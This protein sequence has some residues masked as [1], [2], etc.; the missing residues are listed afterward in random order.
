VKL[1]PDGESLLIHPARSCFWCQFRH[2]GRDCPNV[3]G[4]A[5]AQVKLMIQG[6]ESEK[7]IQTEHELTRTANLVAAFDCPRYNREAGW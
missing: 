3:R 7:L 6:T 2:V 5:L 1:S 4:A